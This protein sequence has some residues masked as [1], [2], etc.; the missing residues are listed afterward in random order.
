LKRHICVAD[1][2]LSSHSMR[3]E[4]VHLNIE[5]LWSVIIIL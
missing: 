2:S 1:L 5:T 3:L 4:C